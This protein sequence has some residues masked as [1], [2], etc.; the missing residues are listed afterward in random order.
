M[1]GVL[2]ATLLMVAVG[3]G[4]GLERFVV[5]EPAMSSQRH[6]ELTDLE[7]FET[8]VLTYDTIREQYVGSDDIT[9]EELIWGAATGM[10][11]ALGDTGH[12]RFLTPDE[13]ERERAALSGELIGI[14]VRVDYT[15]SP[16]V[17]IV[18][19]PDSP[20]FEAGI[21]AGDV[22]VAVDGQSTTDFANP[23]DA[24]GI[25]TG[26]EGTDVTME[27]IHAGETESYEV[28]IT[29]QRFKVD[30]VFWAMLP[31]DVLWVNITE[32]QQ[33]TAREFK[34]ALEAGIDLG[35][36]GVILDLRAN[37]GGLVVEQMAVA[38]QLH[39]SDSVLVQIADS[40]GNITERM[41][42]G[43]N[44]LWQDGPLVVL[45][46]QNSASSAEVVASS[47]QDNERGI[48]VG[49]TT[50]G[51]GTT[52]SPVDF[53]DGSMMWIGVTN[54]LSAD[55][56]VIWHEGIHPDI[57]VVNE[58]GVQLSLPYLFDDADISQEQLDEVED[59]QL[60]TGYDEVIRMIN[61]DNS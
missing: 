7:A 22:I 34:A 14:G 52:L 41:T 46:D 31:G 8:L 21:R 51:T 17:V 37:P 42:R 33:N 54:F 49:Q 60:L 29:R 2:V 19:I 30:S 45:I 58:P 32:F 44:G 40:E 12:S 23:E 50:V 35:A 11:E 16:P 25:L 39:P 27:L 55:G 6:E 9:D 3:F 57:E 38:T 53:P 18:P 47:V 24:M 20:A 28:T 61:E 10:V 4:M 48:L 43:D 59:D 26:D 13:A 1:S 56:N 15:V 5:G 36:K